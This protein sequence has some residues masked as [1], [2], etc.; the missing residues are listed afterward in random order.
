MLCNFGYKHLSNLIHVTIKINQY[1]IDV[2][3]YT[4]VWKPGK[5]YNKPVNE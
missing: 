5:L 4:I 3:F 1:D 2:T